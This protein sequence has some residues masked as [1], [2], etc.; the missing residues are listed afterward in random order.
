MPDVELE[1]RYIIGVDLGTTNSAVAYIDLRDDADASGHRP[2][3]LFEIPQLVAP[4]ELGQRRMLPSFLYLPGAYDLPPGSTALPWDPDRTYAVGE[5]AREQGARVPGRLVASAKS[6]LSHAGVDRTAP[7]LPWGAGTE[8]A[9]VSPVEASM[10]YLLHMREA[11]DAWMAGGNEELAFSKQMIILTVPAS[12]DEV[13]RELTL[14]AAHEAGIPRTI[15]VEEPLAAFYAWLS[16]HERDWQAQMHD[17]QLILVCDVGGG[18]TDFTVVGVRQGERGLR[19][20]RLAVGEHLMLGGDNMD[21]TLGRHLEAKLLGQPGKLDTQRWHQLVHQCRGAKERL[22]QG[23]P[24]GPEGQP[25]GASSVDITVMGAGGQL[26]GGMLKGTLTREE[27]QQL[28]LDGFFP[29]VALNEMPAERRTGL[30]ELGLPYVQDP[31]ITRHLAAFWQRFQTLLREE[32]GRESVYPDF[33]LFNG[34]T[35]IPAAIRARLQQTIQAWFQPVAGAGWEPVELDNPNP[36]LAVALGAAY[37]GLVRLGQGVRVGSGSPRA[38]YVG[39]ETADAP[40]PEGRTTAVCLVP[41]GTEEGFEAQLDQPAFAALTN[42]P[43]SFQ[44]FTSSTRLGDRL[45]DVVHLAPDEVNALPP[46]QSVL[47]YGR[48]VV[49]SIPV[50]LVVRLT[51]IGTLELWCQAQQSEHRWQ[52]QFDVRQEGEP[53]STAPRVEETLDQAAVDAAQAE[54]RQTF[55]GP[56]QALQHPPG[57]L[58]TA[59]EEILGIPRDRWPTHLC[60]QLADTFL[61]CRDGRARSP[62]HEKRWLNLLGFCLRPGFGDPSDDWRMQQV[63]KLYLQGLAFPKEPQCRSEWWIFWRRV[64]G[65]I[66]ARKQVQI[67]DQVWPYLRPGRSSKQKPSPMFP[68]H[69]R[70]GEDIELWMTLASFEWLPAEKKVELG[71]QLLARFRKQSPAARE[72]WALSRLGSR[73]PVYGSLDRVVPSAEAAHW[74]EA[75]LALRLEP[76]ENVGHCLVLLAEYTADRSRDVPEAIRE[77]VAHW[78]AQLPDPERFREL[79]LNPE[80]S[81]HQAEQ[82][83]ILGESLPAGLVLASAV[84]KESPVALAP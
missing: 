81:L 10:R 47:R 34:G 74:I 27:V 20:D 77:Q 31:A 25:E 12:F 7:I 21:M 49:K 30:R 8:I 44:L 79:L 38:Y 35:L 11:W 14:A 64:A 50:Q 24:S 40:D 72:L 43:V 59:L 63:W 69:L 66:A 76:T 16:E 42:Q 53:A 22:L 62:E 75:L 32:T 18:T 15:L 36:E 4:G 29:R 83:W 52:L 33:L 65:G 13:A 37:Y 2:L 58:R 39:V 1:H 3:H 6:W 57:S 19:F 45:G 48:G 17:G 82:G 78:L 46:I 56:D 41:R 70:P 71:R 51:A 84:E 68:K 28:I 60:R 55:Q 26:I 54:I 5:M 73:R 67:F 61:E 9:K 23:V 80:S